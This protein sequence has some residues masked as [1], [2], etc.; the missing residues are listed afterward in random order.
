[1]LT[2][3][4]VSKLS[5]IHDGYE[6][7]YG[8][9]LI[10][11]LAIYF[12]II[13]ISA[14]MSQEFPFRLSLKYIVF[15]RCS[16]AYFALI[17]SNVLISSTLF[18]WESS[19][20]FDKLFLINSSIV[21][22]IISIIIFIFLLTRFKIENNIKYF[23]NDM[24]GGYHEDFGFPIYENVGD[25]K[26]EDNGDIFEFSKEKEKMK[27]IGVT[28]AKI[29]PAL[30]LS[31]DK[32]EVSPQFFI[33]NLGKGKLQIKDW[34]FLKNIDIPIKSLRVKKYEFGDESLTHQVV[35]EY[36]PN[37]NK[38]IQEEELKEILRENISY[39]DFPKGDF[40]EVYYKLKING[41]EEKLRTLILKHI[42]EQENLLEK[43][44]LYSSL[45]S[46]FIEKELT[47]EATNREEIIRAKLNDLYEQKELFF[48]SPS[49][50]SKLQDKLASFLFTEFGKVKEFNRLLNTSGLYIKEF[51]DIRYIDEFK[52]N[53][54]KNWINNFSNLIYNTVTR[55]YELNKLLITLDLEN[56][57]KK[58]YLLIQL[59]ELNKI[60]EHYTY[61]HQTDFLKGYYDKDVEASKKELAD[62]K[63][64]I[65]KKQQEYVKEKQSELFY[66]ILYNIDRE[67]LSK[68][69][70][71]IALKIY[72]LKDFDKQ[73][74]K[75]ERFDKLDWLN[76]D[77]F[78]GG[79][80]TIAP[81]N[82]NRYRLLISFYKLLN[83]EEIDIKRFENENFTSVSYSFE[84]ELDKLSEIF[85]SKY[86]DYDKKK[87]TSFKKKT[88]KEIKEKK[89]S[90]KKNKQDYIIKTP[91]KKEHVSKF[92]IDCRE[93][94]KNTQNEVSEFMQIKEVKGGSKVKS[95]FGQYTL[96]DKEWF[97][98]SFDKNVAL[99]RDSGKDFGRSQANSK[100]KQILDLINKLFDKKKDKEVVI[101]DIYSDLTKLV[102]PNKEYYLF[103]GSDFRIYDI[104]NINWSRKGIE[105]ANLTLNQ[106][107]I[108]LCHSHNPDNLLFEKGSFILKQHKQ[109]YEKIDELLVV[110]IETIDKD[111]EIKEILEKNKKFESE[112]DVKQMVKIRIAEK[113]EIE[114]NKNIK[115]I[116]LKL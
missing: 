47:K 25:Y 52:K 105:T 6:A 92:I 104:P 97:L 58:R 90:I 15:S 32:K 93:A 23:F 72:N 102:Q 13:V 84:K 85:I 54:D 66:L 91:L 27:H 98:D 29:N 17:L 116:R 1:M 74:Y 107:I 87:F 33:L 62:F 5:P 78:G 88:I 80:Q 20:V 112:N 95:F 50:I 14:N 38:A 41:S 64:S 70:F 7:I 75:Y 16:F 37:D 108:H 43:R 55:L 68:D 2:W 26:G 24:I 22:F 11:T 9:A 21:I 10:G 39:K 106:S 63:L 77:W 111:G 56:K 34:N 99:S 60:L 35:C 101:K 100:L 18:F 30:S 109:G 96:F 53:D 79:V 61:L 44:F 3:F 8:A 82:F 103:Y 12:T 40:K 19:Y 76:Y 71:E 73:Y 114:R 115:L 110:Q 46:I 65:I 42:K 86:F 45:M 89:K 59:G 48:N 67:E 28:E 83:N 36:Y 51:L 49:I 4:F 94:W 81:F 113:F 57:T 69:F 31:D